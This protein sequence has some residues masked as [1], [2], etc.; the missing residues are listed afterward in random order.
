MGMSF[1]ELIYFLVAVAVVLSFHEA[2]HALASYYLGDPTAKMH[3]RLSLNPMKH[4]D[5]VG[6]LML[7]LVHFGWGK[8]VPV[9]AANFK[10][11]VVDT[12]I[13]AL[14]GPV[15]NFILALAMALPLRYLHE[16]LPGFLT[17]Q[18]FYI[19]DLSIVWGIFNMIP[20]PPLDGGKIFALFVPH[21]FE[22]RYLEFQETGAK[23]F[24]LFVLFDIMVLKGI[25]GFSLIGYVVMNGYEFV[26]NL[27]LLGM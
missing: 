17:D 23:Y 24:V 21:R 18:L 9:N 7:I 5:V 2:S 10:R 15:S 20:F 6:F 25:L 8:P 26:R 19:F 16:Y 14:A 13:T 1:F 4:I 22:R 12:A 27:M 3:G 11:P